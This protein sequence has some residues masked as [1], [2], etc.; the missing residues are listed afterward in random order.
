MLTASGFDGLR[1]PEKKGPDFEVLEAPGGPDS[2]PVDP[3]VDSLVDSLTRANTEVD[4][5]HVDSG[6]WRPATI[7]ARSFAQ[8][9]QSAT[10]SR[11]RRTPTVCNGRGVLL[12][13][14]RQQR[15]VVIRRL[16]CKMWTCPS[17]SRMMKARLVDGIMSAVEQ[18]QLR[19]F[20]TLTMKPALILAWGLQQFGRP[21]VRRTGKKKVYPGNPRPVAVWEV[22]DL[23]AVWTYVSLV[24]DR[25]LKRL[26]REL[27]KSGREPRFIWVKELHASGIPHLHL[28][29][30]DGEVS[31]RWA[32]AAWTAVGGGSQVRLKTLRSQDGQDD[33]YVALYV[34]KYVSK[35][36]EAQEIGGFSADLQAELLEESDNRTLPIPPGKR[37]FGT[38]RGINLTQAIES[39]NSQPAGDTEEAPAS[40]VWVASRSGFVRRGGTAAISDDLVLEELPDFGLPDVRMFDVL[41]DPDRETDVW[42]LTGFGSRTLSIPDGEDKEDDLEEFFSDLAEDR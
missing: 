31:E 34:T 41:E 19:V 16:R 22:L 35:G 9:S 26:R 39:G 32:K 13:F 12:G 4:T 17:C 10:R 38:S 8:R 24:W 15:R 29:M 5:Q 23:D 2:V 37:R 42:R 25:F 11:V 7:R 18:N 14:L 33:R 27:S 21:I 28:L 30:P 36:F 20:W 6:E 3:W 40:V 1:P